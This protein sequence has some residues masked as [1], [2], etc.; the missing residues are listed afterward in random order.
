MDAQRWQRVKQ[1]L[2]DAM[3]LSADEREAYLDRTCGDDHSLRM[4]VAELMAMD[5]ES[6]SLMDKNILDQI[7]PSE[8]DVDR[9]LTNPEAIGPYRVIRRIGHGG[10]GVVYLARAEDGEADVAI[11][12]IRRD[13][14]SADQMQRFRTEAFIL[15][16]LVH[17]HIAGLLDSGVTEDNRPYIVMEYVQGGD[18]KQY[19]S[20]NA[21]TGRQC[22]QLF[23]KI[24]SAVHF[25]HQNLIVHRDLKPANILIDREGNPKLLDFGIAKLLGDDAEVTQVLTQTNRQIMTPS[26]A[27]PEQ[28]LGTAI[29]TGS[30]VYTLGIILY[31]IL[32]GCKPFE[33]TNPTNPEELKLRI[34]KIPRKPSRAALETTLSND[35][36][37]DIR[38]ARFL[39]GDLDNIILKAMRREPA[40]RYNSVLQMSED[41]QRFLEGKPVIARPETMRYV[42][43]K[44][45]KRNLGKVSFV[46]LVVL[47]LA[48]LS[49]ALNG[50]RAATDKALRR[51]ELTNK[52]LVKLF[53]LP[54]VYKEDGSAYTSL[55]L[56]ERARQNLNSG[57][58]PEEDIYP[59]RLAMAGL[60]RQLRRFDE[61]L[62]L[63]DKAEVAAGREGDDDFLVDILSQR[64][65][66]YH[67]QQNYD[68]AVEAGEAALAVLNRRFKEDERGLNIQLQIQ[69]AE[70]GRGEDSPEELAEIGR[71]AEE[72]MTKGVISPESKIDVWHTYSTILWRQKKNSEALKYLN[73]A[74]SECVDYYGPGH[75]RTSKILADQARTEYSLNHSPDTRA[76]YEQAIIGMVRTYGPNSPELISLYN[77]LG[78]NLSKSREYFKAEEYLLKAY[79]IAAS[80]DPEQRQVI[81]IG[82]NLGALYLKMGELEKAEIYYCR[83][84]EIDPSVNVM[85]DLGYFYLKLRGMEDIG[86]DMMAKIRQTLAD[87]GRRFQFL[88]AEINYAAAEEFRR[89]KRFQEALDWYR[90]AETISLK[91][92]EPN[93]SQLGIVRIRIGQCLQQLGQAKEA[94]PYIHKG[95]DVYRALYKEDPKRLLGIIKGAKGIL[96]ACGDK[97]AVAA[98]EK[99]ALALAAQ[100]AGK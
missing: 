88:S 86:F 1:I 50:Q 19:L 66:L 65:Y 67:T 16:K 82:R 99:E 92:L 8:E 56:L 83:N 61:A 74:L 36:A 55:E 14:L 5:E 37:G 38:K 11:K 62:E 58:L 77:D 12:V 27:S 15:E 39:K 54:T 48:G 3:T 76:K 60:Y 94:I 91:I 33:Q 98:Y 6:L 9:H 13:V 85:Y 42:M 2:E 49:I 20:E 59:V 87:E 68:K 93:A 21:L 43:G 32:S 30:D 29:S 73:L 44:F 63:M 80:I 95:V 53:N 64:A 47:G 97:E 25:A 70:Y 18:L 17:P 79:D 41:I 57:D 26:Y 90:E 24:C 52:F 4:E 28:I 10:M 69:M 71:L 89:L 81:D 35:R 84:L 51:A 40:R 31:E 22:L 75:A 34:E 46:A 100:I 72:I 96:Q 23:Q 78:V 7:Q 45:V